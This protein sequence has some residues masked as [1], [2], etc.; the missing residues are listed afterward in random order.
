MAL[1]HSIITGRKINV[2]RIIVNKTL[3]CIEMGNINLLFPLLITNLCFQHKVPK[4]NSDKALAIKGTTIS[5]ATWRHLTGVETKEKG[6]KRMTEPTLKIQ[7]CQIY[8]STNTS[9]IFA[10]GTCPNKSKEVLV[11]Y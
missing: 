6:K 1:L 4:L 8:S 10:R 2:K 9:K 3:K 7:G 11:K 5:P